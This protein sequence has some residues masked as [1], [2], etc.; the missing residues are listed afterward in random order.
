MWLTSFQGTVTQAI[1][2]QQP[3]TPTVNPGD[4]TT[5]T[6]E[7]TTPTTVAP[8]V[9]ELTGTVN[10]S[11][12]GLDYPSVAA[13]LKMISQL[14]VVRRPLGPEHHE[15]DARRHTTRELHLDA[16]R[17]RPRR[18]PTGSSGTEAGKTR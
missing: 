2:L 7:G 9:G 18:A 10:F 12:V 15:G 14:P 16:R 13:W 3:T 5:T 17:S 11:A 8:T 4:E 1:V 6:A